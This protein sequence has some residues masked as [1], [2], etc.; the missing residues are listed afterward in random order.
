M[1]GFIIMLIVIILI[2]FSISIYIK[3]DIKRTQREIDELITLEKLNKKIDKAL[4]I[5]EDKQDTNKNIKENHKRKNYTTKK[6]EGYMS[7]YHNKLE[8]L[9]K[10]LGTQYKLSIKEGKKGNIMLVVEDSE[11]ECYEVKFNSRKFNE[12]SN[13]IIIAKIKKAIKGE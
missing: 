13:T 8:S 5:V 6:G 1:T 7:K 11:N 3:Y 10:T 9:Y 4:E 2:L 12:T